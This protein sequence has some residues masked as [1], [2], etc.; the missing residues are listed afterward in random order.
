MTNDID[1]FCL[2]IFT[3][4]NGLT[5][6]KK[7]F[8]PWYE[9]NMEQMITDYVKFLKE[10]A[11]GEKQLFEACK[12]NAPLHTMKQSLKEMVMN[13]GNTPPHYARIQSAI[14]NF[15]NNPYP[16]IKRLEELNKA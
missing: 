10:Q 2:T 6:S 7:L 1:N 12:S 4:A 3:Q 15:L 5:Q 14:D 13:G 8:A 16:V 11:G 9:P